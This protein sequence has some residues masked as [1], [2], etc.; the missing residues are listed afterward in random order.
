MS[1]ELAVLFDSL[2]EYVI[3]NEQFWWICVQSDD[4]N[5]MTMQFDDIHHTI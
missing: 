4:L 1:L 3:S 5:G 2:S